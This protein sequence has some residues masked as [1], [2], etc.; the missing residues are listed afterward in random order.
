MDP[1]ERE[2]RDLLTSDRRD[3]PASLVP[4]DRV[5]AG[6]SRR[7][8][9]RAA[10]ASAATAVAVLAVAGTAA[11]AGF[12]PDDKAPVADSTPTVSRSIVPAPVPTSTAPDSTIDAPSG[13]AW[14]AARVTSVTA[15]STRTF[16]VLGEL[17]DTGACRPPDCV[18]LAETHDGGR[19]FSALP[20]PDD[21]RGAVEGSDADSATSVRFGSAQDG[22]LF[23]GGMW[24]THDGGHS[25]VRT[26]MPGRVTRVE[27]AA[28]SAWALVATGADQER[29]LLFRTD[30][31]LDDWQQ[32]PDVQ[33]TGPADLAVHG[34]QVVVMGAQQSRL[35]VGGPHGFA[36][37]DSPCPGATF[38]RLSSVGSVWATCGTGTSAALEVSTDGI[39]WSA[40]PVS[41]ANGALPNSVAVGARSL[42]QAI[43]SL[44][45]EEPLSRL[46]TDGTDNPVPDP[47]TTG[48]ATTYLGFTTPDVG[49][50]IVGTRL[51]R[52]D[53]GGDTWT[54]AQI[55]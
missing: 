22:W 11:G 9:N 2:L 33:V 4:L 55:S 20:I 46:S 14:G 47:P 7:R 52:T 24:S 16:V 36:E 10:V 27:A 51:W 45:P 21:A 54:L 15:T 35:W 53:D 23:G 19:T 49:Y 25:W 13:P 48:V 38:A 26:D 50:A 1:L 40:V 42:R 29:L 17:G 12:L 8:R 44:G 41:Q 37:H 39:T 18:R 5:H 6:A 32:V 3:L 34:D 31:G 30:V 43:V 28:G